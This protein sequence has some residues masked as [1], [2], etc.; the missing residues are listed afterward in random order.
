MEL[1][2]KPYIRNKYQKGGI[3]I[4]NPSPKFWLVEIQKLGLSLEKI[5]VYAVPSAIANEIYGCILIFD[6]TIRINDIG[7]NY[8][9]QIIENKLIIPEYSDYLPRMT[10]QEFQLLFPN[11]YF[12]LHPDFGLYELSEKIN[13]KTILSIPQPE[14]VSI[15]EPLKSVYIPNQLQSLRVE[16]NIEQALNT[17][18][19]PFDEKEFFEKLPFDMQKVLK[20]NQKEIDKYLAFLE[21]NPEMALKFAIP[22]DVTG[23]SRGG[24][25]GNFSMGKS[26]FPKVSKLLSFLGVIFLFFM[27]VNSIA[28]GNFGL[29]VLIVIFL[30]VSLSKKPF[31]SQGHGG[32]SALVDNDRFNK[33]REKYNKLAETYASQNQHHKAANIYLKL[34]KDKFKAAEVMEQGK[35]YG[36]AAAIYLTHCDNK[37]KAAEC[38]EN[39]KMYLQAI[40][41]YREL[42]QKEKVGDLYILNNNKPEADKYFTVVADDYINNSQYV[43]ASLIYKKKIKDPQKTQD[44]LIKGWRNNNDAYNCLNNYFS[45]IKQ[46]KNLEKAISGIYKHE[47]FLQNK[48]VF[49]QVIKQEFIKNDDLKP[50]TKDIAYE[51]ISERITSNPQIVSELMFFNKE[52][53]QLTKDII[54]YK[55]YSK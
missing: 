11:N 9:C 30:V 2:L 21:K 10:S 50:L 5:D 42:D 41:I 15:I 34:L 18:E 44:L 6:Q 19:Q 39:G 23:S 14:I 36:E 51:I 25:G 13:W 45:N 37:L 48:E 33:L 8:Y 28:S 38:Y 1:K 16:S 24:F 35:Y 54:K 26:N 31:G 12:I 53:K 29:L 43:K 3:L 47:V 32:K 22:L 40:E 4:K 17:L 55:L 49:L 27:G 46:T 20:G 7:K 52:D